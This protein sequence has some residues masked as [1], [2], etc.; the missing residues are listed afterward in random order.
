LRHFQT[1]SYHT[2]TNCQHKMRQK[3]WFSDR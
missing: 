1:Q 2:A 3:C